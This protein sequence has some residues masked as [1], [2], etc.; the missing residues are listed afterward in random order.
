LGITR[1]GSRKHGPVP[2]EAGTSTIAKPSDTAAGRAHVRPGVD[3]RNAS[4]PAVAK[5]NLDQELY[6]GVT[7]VLILFLGYAAWG[8]VTDTSNVGETRQPAD[9]AD[10][11]APTGQKTSGT[12]WSQAASIGKTLSPAGV[13]S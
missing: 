4:A 11:G 2:E 12:D 1:N 13:S 3:E 9:R 10:R 6:V 7:A 5:P 8:V